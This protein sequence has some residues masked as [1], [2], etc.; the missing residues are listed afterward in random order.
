MI[1]LYHKV[2]L[3]SSTKWWVDIDD[4]YRQMLEIKP[5]KVV[6]LD[7]YNP[8]DPNQV[9]ITFDGVYQNILEFAAPIL[10]EFSYPFELFIIGDSI[11][12]GNAFD[13]T[14]PPAKFVSLMGLKELVR[15]G[16]RLQWH[17]RSHPKLD[18]IKEKKKIRKELTVPSRLKKIDKKG[19]KWFAYPH[20]EHNSL[21]LESVRENFRGALS[22]DQGNNKDM[23]K[24]N[25]ITVTNS[26]SFKKGTI[27]VIIT[28]Y[29]YGSYLPEAV[30]SVLRQTR[31]ADNIL[32]SDDFSSD[33]TQS[34]AENYVKKY[35]DMISYNRNKKNLGI[36]RHFKKA[37]G[38]MKTD[39]ICFLG[40]DNRFRSDYLEKCSAVLDSNNNT[41]IA[42]TDFALFGQRAPAVYEDLPEKWHG[43][44]KGNSY[45]IINFPE[46]NKKSAELLRTRNFMH[47]SS[48]YKKKAYQEA[49]GY[50]LKSKGRP[51]DHSL[52]YRIIKKGWTAKRVAEPILEYRQHSRDQA[53]INFGFFAQLNFYKS[54][55]NKATQELEEARNELNKIKSSKMWKLLYIYKNPKEAIPHYLKRIF[56]II[57]KKYSEKR[58]P[59]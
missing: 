44:V 16:G 34:I 37:S 28:S 3:E 6:Y 58:S 40:A 55:Y 12:K 51:E 10:K 53:N 38:L 43:P 49:G 13:K 24:L 1:L 23:Y 8:E 54:G 47:G 50:R 30:E 46:F 19:F 36:V 21:V 35:P 25:R 48:M 42:Y 59:N 15:F 9:A 31:P 52:F 57:L 5:K 32:I 14:E 20:G 7:D 2:Y 56:E 11:G 39:Y 33:D 27:G 29:N 17:T 41:G 18:A 45:Y 4:F 26:S 22:V